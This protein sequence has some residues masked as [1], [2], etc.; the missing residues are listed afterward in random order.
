MT[1]QR[2]WKKNTDGQTHETSGSRRPADLGS[3]SRFMAAWKAG[4]LVSTYTPTVEPAQMRRL[5]RRSTSAMVGTLIHGVS[6]MLEKV[7][8]AVVMQS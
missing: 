3:K 2:S 8:H 1:K 5:A 4:S 7:S 6:T